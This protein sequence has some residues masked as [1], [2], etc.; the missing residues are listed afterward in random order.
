MDTLFGRH[1]LPM[2]K[3]LVTTKRIRKDG[4]LSTIWQKVSVGTCCHNKMKL[5]S[6]ERQ[7]QR[8]VIVIGNLDLALPSAVKAMMLNHLTIDH[9]NPAL[10]EF[11]A[12][13]GFLLTKGQPGLLGPN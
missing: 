4:A 1:L 13:A 5:L 6:G 12:V 8:I 3:D 10:E 2:L 11:K 9:Y 7:V